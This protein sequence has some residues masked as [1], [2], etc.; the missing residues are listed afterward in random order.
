MSGWINVGTPQIFKSFVPEEKS[1][2][3]QF[4]LT[5]VLDIQDK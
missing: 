4:V 1:K 3:L 5:K 2:I